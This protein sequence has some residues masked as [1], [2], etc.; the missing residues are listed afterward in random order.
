MF[1]LSLQYTWSSYWRNK[2][3]EPFS[4]GQHNNFPWPDQSMAQILEQQLQVQVQV[5]KVHVLQQVQLLLLVNYSYNY[6][7]LSQTLALPSLSNSR[8]KAL[9]L[10]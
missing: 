1:S 6:K 9:V 4:S 10:V 5:Y 2:V 3:I 7:S 8:V